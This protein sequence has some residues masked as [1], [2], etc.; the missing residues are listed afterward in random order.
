[1]EVWLIYRALI[2]WAH[3]SLIQINLRF[4][5]KLL[6]LG[7]SISAEVRE[8]STMCLVMVCYVTYQVLLVVLQSRL[9]VDPTP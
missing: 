6:V 7:S 1:M 4:F 8:F 3:L 9:L 2:D 5:V